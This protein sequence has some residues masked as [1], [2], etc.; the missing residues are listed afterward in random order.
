LMFIIKRSQVRSSNR[1]GTWRQ[2]L[3]KRTTRVL[4]TG[5][6]IVTCSAC[7]LI[8]PRTTSPRTT[9]PKID[10]I[11]PHQ[12]INQLIKCPTGL[13][14]TLFYAGIFKLRFPLLQEILKRLTT[15]PT[16]QGSS[17]VFSSQQILWPRAP[18]TC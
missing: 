7:F 13:T 5:L 4:L 8:E 12:L 18:E 3:M 10:W 16:T 17:Q 9:S 15:S 1:A 6:L 11:L 2:E 14:T